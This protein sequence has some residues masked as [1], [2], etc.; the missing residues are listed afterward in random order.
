M[1]L[2]ADTVKK[3]ALR[4]VSIARLGAANSVHI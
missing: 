3:R 1:I 4:E 2:V